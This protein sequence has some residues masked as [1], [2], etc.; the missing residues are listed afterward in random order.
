M[1]TSDH[2]RELVASWRANASPWISAVRER[3]ISSRELGTNQ[4]ILDAIEAGQPR[5]V[6]DLGCGEGWLVRALAARGIDAIGVDGSPALIEAARSAGGHYLCLDYGEL[7]ALD[8]NQLDELGPIDLAVAN[9]ALLG[10]DIQTPLRASAR[11]LGARP[12]GLRRLLIQTLHPIVAGP[13]YRAG[14]RREDFAAFEAAADEW[15]PMPWY[16]RPL[17]GWIQALREAGFVIEG[18]REPLHPESGLPLSL[19]IEADLGH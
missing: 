4:A 1:P 7:T 11:V 9:F 2:E 14:W 15:A 8:S 17:G 3:Q 5:R 16:F 19:V 13:P 12:R 10:R 6:L 18:L